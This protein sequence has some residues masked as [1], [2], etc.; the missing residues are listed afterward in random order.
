MSEKLYTAEDIDRATS[1]TSDLR[2]HDHGRKYTQEEF[3]EMVALRNKIL[4]GL[5][6]DED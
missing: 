4:K 1:S 2:F 6:S 5:D 3:D